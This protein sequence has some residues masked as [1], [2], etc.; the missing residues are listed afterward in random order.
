MRR[1]EQVHALEVGLTELILTRGWYIYLVGTTTTLHSRDHPEAL[2][3]F[4]VHRY[5]DKDYKLA[6]K[7]E[8]K[9]DRG[10]RNLKRER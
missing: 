5:L 4:Y 7:K 2:E 10:G 9:S 3:V 6:T 8:Q 1:G